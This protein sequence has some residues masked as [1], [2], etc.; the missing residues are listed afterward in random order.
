MLAHPDSQMPAEQR[1]DGTVGG[2]GRACLAYLADQAD[3]RS[4]RAVRMEALSLRLYLTAASL[5][6]TSLG[7]TLPP[8]PKFT[9]SPEEPSA[10][11][12]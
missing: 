3:S 8:M 1:A 4:L 6:F 7:T 2:V 12:T 11:A 5:G 10:A 9:S